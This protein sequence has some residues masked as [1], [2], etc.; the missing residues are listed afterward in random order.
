MDNKNGFLSSGGALFHRNHFDP[1]TI[2]SD[3]V[4]RDGAAAENLANDLE[5]GYK[6]FEEFACTA[7]AKE[8]ISAFLEKRP[9]NFTK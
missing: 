8:G 9:A 6:G 1:I 5:I 3:K 2:K 7:A 4:I